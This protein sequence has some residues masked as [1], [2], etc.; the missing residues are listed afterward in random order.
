[1]KQMFAL[2]ALAV[3]MASCNTRY[4]KS[5]SGLTY[6]IFK[7]NDKGALLKAGMFAKLNLEYVLSPKDSVLNST[8]G[9][10]PH[11]TAVDT[12]ART[13]YSFMELLPKVKQGD[14]VVFTISVDTLKNRGAIPNYN[15]IFKRGDQIKCKM[16]VLKTFNNEND[17]RKDYDAEM[18]GEREREI[19]DIQAYLAKKNIKAQR[20]KNGAFVEIVNAGDAQKAQ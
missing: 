20:T 2:A 17:I 8:Y 11:F 14:S 9:K 6:K 18:T 7:G 12:S 13:A 1:M 4:E 19:K 3:V 15:E 10:V 16:T 5:K